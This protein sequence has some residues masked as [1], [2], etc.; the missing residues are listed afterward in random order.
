MILS[1]RVE[2]SLKACLRTQFPLLISPYLHITVS[3][4][5]VEET[6]VSHT[7]L[8][9]IQTSS[10]LRNKC[11]EAELGFRPISGCIYVCGEVIDEASQNALLESVKLSVSRVRLFQI[12]FK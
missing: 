7:F 2:A 3:L 4:W 8:M 10:Q 11:S 12:D 6:R 9:G 1:V 5:S